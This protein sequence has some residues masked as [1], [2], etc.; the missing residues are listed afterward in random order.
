L[1]FF[2]IS[3]T[4]KVEL[5]L[6]KADSTPNNDFMKSSLTLKEERHRENIQLWT[7][8]CF[9]KKHFHAYPCIYCIFHEFTLH[10]IKWI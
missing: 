6:Y 5:L 4:E 9:W 7:F 1:F 8:K 10:T 2:I 3:L